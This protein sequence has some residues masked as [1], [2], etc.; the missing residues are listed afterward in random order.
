MSDD[1]E[2]LLAS[3]RGILMM[4]SFLDDVRFAHNGRQVILS[5]TRSSG[6][7][8]RKDDR[9]ALTAPF[10]VTPLLPNGQPDW[11]ASYEAMSRN[12]SETGVAILQKHL[13]QSQ[14][15]LI[16]IPTSQGIMNFPAEIKHTRTFGDSGMELGCRF[17][18]TS[19]AAPVA[20]AP[21]QL[22]EVEQAISRFLESHHARQAPPHE[23]RIHPR[24][25]FNERVTIHI[26]DRAQPIVG[27]ARDLSKGGLAII[28]QEAVP[29]EITITF[30]LGPDREP[31]KVRCRVLRCQCIQT[32]F[33][34]V[35][36]AFLRLA[37][38]DE[39]LGGIH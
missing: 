4:K 24:I 14:Q 20:E 37:S 3:G 7:E 36:A 23:R 29:A 12:V 22:V 25:V 21:A 16:G 5:L 26:A 10:Q 1:P 11:A 32:G 15:I 27:Y 8:K 17:L 35:G 2:I 30:V 33:Y 18:P 38:T 13:T 19:T 6:T 9:V 39:S 31:L 28:T 34:D